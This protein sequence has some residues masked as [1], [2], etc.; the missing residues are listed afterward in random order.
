[1]MYEKMYYVLTVIFAITYIILIIHKFVKG[2][3]K[4]T[5]ELLI[6]MNLSQ[7]LL[8]IITY[9]LQERPP[10]IMYDIIFD[11]QKITTDDYYIKNN[12]LKVST[13]GQTTS[14]KIKDDSSFNVIL[15]KN[16]Y[17]ITIKNTQ[18]KYLKVTKYEVSR[19]GTTLYYE[20][21]PSTQLQ[22]TDLEIKSYLE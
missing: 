7:S 13:N 4:Q 20:N 10:I 9:P 14:Y 17:D 16:Y 11:G 1:M 21:K 18:E 22:T 3:Y 5:V 6:L 8:F 12:N 19:F 2:L 15:R